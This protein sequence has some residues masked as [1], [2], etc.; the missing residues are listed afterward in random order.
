MPSM[1]ISEE[2]FIGRVFSAT[3]IVFYCIL[4]TYH[5]KMWRNVARC[6][7]LLEVSTAATCRVLHG[8]AINRSNPHP[9]LQ[10][11]EICF[12]SDRASKALA[13]ASLLGEPR[14]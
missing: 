9:H 5:V 13:E 3:L 7:V 2:G 11:T 14:T 1:L 8:A 10:G 12:M 4:L 6:G